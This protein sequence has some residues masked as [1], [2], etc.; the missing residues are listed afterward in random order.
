MWLWSK[1]KLIV[2]VCTLVFVCAGMPVWISRT[3]ASSFWGGYFSRVSS[4]VSGLVLTGILTLLMGVPVAHLVSK[5][6]KKLRERSV[7]R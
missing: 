7:W 4:Q 2:G 5:T 1:K 6:A 3:D